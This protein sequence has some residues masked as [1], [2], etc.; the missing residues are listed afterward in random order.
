M[1]LGD[2]DMVHQW[3]H[4]TYTER[5]KMC[6]NLVK[7]QYCCIIYCNRWYSRRVLKA[8]VSTCQSLSK[9]RHNRDR[10]KFYSA[11]GTAAARR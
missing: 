9:A 3:Y 2:G 4:R 1:P 8:G 7:L 10:R 6:Y 5:K 11:N